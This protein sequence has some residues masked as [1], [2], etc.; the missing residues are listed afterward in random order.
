MVTSPPARAHSKDNNFTTMNAKQ[1]SQRWSKNFGQ[2]QFYEGKGK[3]LAVLS[4]VP[5]SQ[6]IVLLWKGLLSGAHGSEFD[7]KWLGVT[8][9]TCVVAEWWIRKFAWHHVEI[10]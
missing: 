4:T 7:E 8:N 6:R 10:H 3:L 1:E 9:K 5:Q 2:H